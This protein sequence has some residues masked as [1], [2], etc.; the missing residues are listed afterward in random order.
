MIDLFSVKLNGSYDFIQ[1]SVPSGTGTWL[2]S[3]DF[4][5]YNK[6]ESYNV[7]SGVPTQIETALDYKI[8]RA[9]YPTIQAVCEWLNNYF[10]VRRQEDN[11]YNFDEPDYSTSITI[12]KTFNR[13]TSNYG[14]YTFIG[15]NISSI[16]NVAFIEGD[17]TQIRDSN[18]NNL[19]SYV[20]AVDSSSI[21]IDNTNSVDTVENALLMLMNV[22]TNVE[23]IISAMI[24]YDLVQRGTPSNLSSES[25]GNY[26]YSKDNTQ[27]IKIGALDYPSSQVS[28]LLAYKKVRVI[29]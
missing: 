9:I 8:E 25:I 27:M 4:T 22:P 18:R 24:Y 6:G 3:D 1:A 29:Q 15:G 7:V 2:V 26:S 20:S 16:K 17:L 28:G 21:T 13:Y 23:D 19:V 12:S 10:Y 11:N 5:G 14:N